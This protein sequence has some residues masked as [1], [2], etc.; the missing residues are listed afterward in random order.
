MIL[1]IKKAAGATTQAAKIRK[2]LK[3]NDIQA[4]QKKLKYLLTITIVYWL[5]KSICFSVVNRIFFKKI[6]CISPKQL[7]G[8]YNNDLFNYR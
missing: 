1:E 6:A 8:E 7:D 2:T 3:Y 5:K 4:T